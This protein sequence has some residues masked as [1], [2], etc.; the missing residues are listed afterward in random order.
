MRRIIREGSEARTAHGD[1]AL[2]RN[3]TLRFMRWLWA[4]DHELQSLSKRMRARI[5]LTGRQRLVV[6]V[7]GQKPGL[8]A[9]ELAMVLRLHRS[10]ITGVLQRLEQLG[11]LKRR[12]SPDDHRRTV[13]RLTAA[14]RALDRER[15][16]T[17]ESAVR[18][19]LQR[20]SSKAVVTTAV[21]LSVV[22]DE[23]RHA[24]GHGRR[25]RG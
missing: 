18:T 9:S 17:V 11:I 22:A 7:L 3:Q 15:R 2:L 21:V 10:T 6:R 13:L 19:A 20:V 4:V 24:A 8:S 12:T 5:G 25:G 16:G 14:G 1:D 23:L